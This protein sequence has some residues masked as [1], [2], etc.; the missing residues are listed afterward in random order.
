VVPVF[1]LYSWDADVDPAALLYQWVPAVPNRMGEMKTVNGAA[2]FTS[3][4]QISPVPE[5]GTCALPLAGP[6]LIG[7][8][9][10]RASRAQEA[11]VMALP[12]ATDVP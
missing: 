4:R 11:I 2:A 7:W 3:V 9:R 10:R 8:Q 5:P 1:L 6:G 12:V